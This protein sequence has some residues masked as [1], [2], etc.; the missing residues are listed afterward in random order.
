LNIQSQ[1][2]AEISD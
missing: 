1:F 2:S